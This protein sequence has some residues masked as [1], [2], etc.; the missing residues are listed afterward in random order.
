MK[1]ITQSRPAASFVSRQSFLEGDA[2]GCLFCI[3]KSQTVKQVIVATTVAFNLVLDELTFVFAVHGDCNSVLGSR[4]ESLTVPRIHGNVLSIFAE[5]G[6]YY[7]RR[8]YRIDQASFYPRLNEML[9]P[10]LESPQQAT[11]GGGQPNGEIECERNLSIALRYF[12]S[13]DI[14]DIV[15]SH[16]VFPHSRLSCCVACR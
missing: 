8:A 9:R 11:P 12:T 3:M 13:G 2:F 16:G 6:P 15:I 14:Y 7:S 10:F 1:S 5:Y 4:A